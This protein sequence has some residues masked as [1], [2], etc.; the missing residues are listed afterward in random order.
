MPNFEINGGNR[1]LKHGPGQSI[2]SLSKTQNLLPYGVESSKHAF[3]AINFRTWKCAETT[4]SKQYQH[5]FQKGQN[6]RGSKG[7]FL[8]GKGSQKPPKAATNIQNI[9]K[10]LVLACFLGEKGQQI[11]WKRPTPF[12]L[13]RLRWVKTSRAEENRSRYRFVST[14]CGGFPGSTVVGETN[15]LFRD[16]ED[17]SFNFAKKM[18]F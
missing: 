13:N 5:L 18:S 16:K 12:N 9:A 7:P 3:L 10:V 4:L 1:H 11:S 8:K 2:P 14:V 6:E 15:L 17:F